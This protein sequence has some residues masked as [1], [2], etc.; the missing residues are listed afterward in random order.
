MSDEKDKTPDCLT[1]LTEE[2]LVKRTTL[3]AD[4]I[5]RILRDSAQ[6]MSERKQPQEAPLLE[7]ICVV[8]QGKITEQRWSTLVGEPVYGGPAN[9]QRHS[10]LYC[11]GCGI[12]YHH[13]P[14]PKGWLLFFIVFLR[15]MCY[16]MLMS[17]LTIS[18]I[19]TFETSEQEAK[20]ALSWCE[21]HRKTCKVFKMPSTSGGE[22]T[23]T[24]G[25]N[26]IGISLVVSC[27]CGDSFDATDYNLWWFYANRPRFY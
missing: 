23:Y 16:D 4:D 17:D 18:S 13:L 2:Q 15:F 8:C 25:P 20:S 3:T 10:L 22:F 12:Q 14:K 21:K 19:L 26:A 7:G 27:C 1:P 11:T 6:K 9:V 24:F 5:R